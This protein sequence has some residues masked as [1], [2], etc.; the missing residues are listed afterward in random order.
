MS[1]SPV[2]VAHFL[3]VHHRKFGTFG[4]DNLVVTSAG[5]SFFFLHLPL[6][7]TTKA[8]VLSEEH[9]E[10]SVYVLKHVIS[11][12]KNCVKPLQDHANFWIRVPS[13]LA[14]G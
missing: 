14:C 11:N 12:E 2:I 10:C 4:L 9:I 3:A 6:L 8:D 13:I 1:A 5:S 7:Q